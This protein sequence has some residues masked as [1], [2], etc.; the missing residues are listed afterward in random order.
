MHGNL[1][2][3]PF[4]GVKNPIDNWQ[5]P[6]ALILFPTRLNHSWSM[7]FWGGCFDDILQ[8]LSSRCHI[9]CTQGLII[10]SRWKSWNLEKNCQKVRTCKMDSLV[11]NHVCRVKYLHILWYLLLTRSFC[12]FV[13]KFAMHHGT[14]NTLLV[15]W[16]TIHPFHHHMWSCWKKGTKVDDEIEDTSSRNA[17]VV[18]TFTNTIVPWRRLKG[19]FLPHLHTSQFQQGVFWVGDLGLSPKRSRCTVVNW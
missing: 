12:F 15:A 7:P 1:F 16:R 9:I 4:I 5:W 13:C 19:W 3:G 17:S 11:I 8:C 18:G 10:F 2:K 14:A 6:R